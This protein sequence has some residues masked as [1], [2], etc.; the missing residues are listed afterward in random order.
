LS[1][2][3]PAAACPAQRALTRSREYEADRAGARLLGDGEP[4]AS[5]L[6][7]IEAGVRSVPMNVEPAA[8][9][10]FIVNPLTGRKVAFAN[11]FRTHPRTADRVARL[12]SGERRSC[13]APV[14]PAPPRGGAV[15]FR[16]A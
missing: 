12:R 4:L 2:L 16:Y 3:A 11:F 7:K 8:A 15:A 9:S 1:S 14:P 10:L 6:E 13:A 5:A